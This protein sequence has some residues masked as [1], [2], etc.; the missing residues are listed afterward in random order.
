M[1]NNNIK[2]LYKKKLYRSY[3]LDVNVIK[4]TLNCLFYENKHNY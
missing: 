4:V 3:L 1:N 2:T